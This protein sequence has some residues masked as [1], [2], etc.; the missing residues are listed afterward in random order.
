M[1]E[2][3]KTSDFDYFLPDELIAQVPAEPRDSSRLMIFNRKGNTVSH[4]VFREL[5]NFI[6]RGDVLVLNHSRVIPARLH[7]IMNAATKAE[8]LLLKRTGPRVFEALIR[9]ARRAKIGSPI[10]FGDKLSAV[11]SEIKGEGIVSAEF[12][13]DGVFEELLDEIGETPLPHYIKRGPPDM[14]RYQTVYAKKN[15]SAAAPTAG[16]H[17]TEELL[18]ELLGNGVEIA[19]VLLH[20]GLGTFRPVK[21]E[22]LSEH[23]MHGEYYEISEDAANK[24]NAAKIEGGRIIAVGTTAVRTLESA[25]DKDGLIMPSSGET[26]IFI[27]PPYKFRAVD[28]LVT[29]FHLPKSSLLMLVSAFAGYENTMRLYK[30]AVEERYNFFSFGDAMLIL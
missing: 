23:K 17:F 16:L 19:E 21:A 2:F 12:E 18:G 8:L 30:T 13:F 25:A 27:Y 15:G 1:G 10:S 3:L 24:I 28:A 6:R 5:T 29:N 9:P 20:V 11:I 4:G 7:G 22:T 26:D 14:R